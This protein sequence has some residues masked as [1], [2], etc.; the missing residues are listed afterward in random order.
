MTTA[1]CRF[2]G[3]HVWRFVTP[4]HPSNS[5]RSR[6]HAVVFQ[7]FRHSDLLKNLAEPVEGGNVKHQQRR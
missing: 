2:S 5:V 1:T 7:T 3:P 4:E 6:M